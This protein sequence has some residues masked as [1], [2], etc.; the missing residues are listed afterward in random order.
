MLHPFLLH[1]CDFEIRK[2][3]KV[4]VFLQLR[5]LDVWMDTAE[6]IGPPDFTVHGV[7]RT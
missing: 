3:S 2:L 5:S 4:Y 7:A 6:I 1:F